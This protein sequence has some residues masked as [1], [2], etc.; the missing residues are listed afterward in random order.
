MAEATLGGGRGGGGGGGVIV[1][2]G[3]DGEFGGVDGGEGL[4]GGE[5]DD[6]GEDVVEGCFDEMVGFEGFGAAGGDV[7]DEV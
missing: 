6:V 5:G 1:V 4:L 7:S 3:E 2:V